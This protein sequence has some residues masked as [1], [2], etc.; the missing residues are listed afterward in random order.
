MAIERGGFLLFLGFISAALL[1]IIWPFAAPLLWATL[2]AIMFQ[3]LYR[4]LL[5]W[6]KGRENQ[7]ALLS[8]LIITVAVIIPAFIIGSMIADEALSVFDAFR[9]GDIDVATKVDQVIAALPLSLQSS[10]SD[11]GWGDMAALLESES[12]DCKDS[13]RAAMTWSTLVATSMSP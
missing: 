7:A 1:V 3:P 5:S 6:R 9:Q 8:L 11:S 10:L 12:E 4:R 2:A 13:G